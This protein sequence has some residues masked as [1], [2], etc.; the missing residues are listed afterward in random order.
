MLRGALGEKWTCGCCAREEA[1]VSE[2]GEIE[3]YAQEYTQEN[4]PPKPL[5][6]KTREADFHEFL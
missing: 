4:T 1:L 6:G 3:W 2:K 5:A